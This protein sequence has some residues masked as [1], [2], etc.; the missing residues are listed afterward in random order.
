MQHWLLLDGI[1]NNHS[2]AKKLL[3]EILNHTDTIS[4][5]T[6]Y[7]T[8][9][10]LCSSV[11]SCWRGRGAITMEG[12][13]GQGSPLDAIAWVYVRRIWEEQGSI[14]VLLTTHLQFQLHE[15]SHI[16]AGRS[17]NVQGENLHVRL[18]VVRKG[19]Y[20]LKSIEIVRWKKW[21]YYKKYALIWLTVC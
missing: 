3:R 15:K 2:G 1:E 4:L 19:Q 10:Q 6:T 5:S 21:F 14:F 9:Q 20:I 18:Y 12:K 16:R 8:V 17:H 7:G 13:R 11:D